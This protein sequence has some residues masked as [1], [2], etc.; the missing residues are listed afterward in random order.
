MEGNPVIRQNAAECNICGPGEVGG[1]RD[2]GVGGPWG[3]GGGGGM[4]VL[5]LLI[6]DAIIERDAVFTRM[7]L[8]TQLK[9]GCF[10]VVGN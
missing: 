5:L 2:L 9:K 6:T 10:V 1:D 4:P 7:K 3:G 8:V